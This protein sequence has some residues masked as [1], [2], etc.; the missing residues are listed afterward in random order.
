M[1]I[2]KTNHP[3]FGSLKVDT[4]NF[5][6]TVKGNVAKVVGNIGG[7]NHVKGGNAVVNALSSVLSKVGLTKTDDLGGGGY[8]YLGDICSGDIYRVTGML[9]AKLGMDKPKKEFNRHNIL[10]KL[11]K[12]FKK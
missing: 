12:G 5:L 8:E 7:F 4:E 9:R 3:E 6:A 1:K 10:E 2:N 11:G